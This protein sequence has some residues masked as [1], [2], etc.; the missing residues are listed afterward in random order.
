MKKTYPFY[1]KVTVI[2]FGLTLLVYTLINLR[3]ILTP[4][5]FSLL[6][7]VLLNRLVLK[8]EHFRVP[9][10][11]AISIAILLAFTVIGGVAYFISTQIM[12]FGDDLPLLK[13][14]FLVLFNE[15]Q[16][17]IRDAFGV[18]I[19]QQDIWIAEAESG[20]KPM[21]GQTLGTVAGTI[22]VM[23]LLPV[24]T[25]VLLFYK[26]HFL[27]FLYEVFGDS[28]SE[29]V[30]DVLRETKG[31]IQRYM[32]GL[33]LEGIVVAILNTT[34]LFIFDIKYAI[35]LGVTAAILN[36][37]PYIGGFIAILLPI[38]VA[39]ITKDGIQ[40]QVG[41][42]LAYLFI[43]FL[44]NHVLIPLIVSSRVKINAFISIV[45]VLLGGAM[46]GVPGMFLS[47]P[48][49]G[50]LKIIFDRIEELKPWGKMLGTEEP[51][52]QKIKFV[53]RKRK[54]NVS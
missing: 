28:D 9:K 44:D 46:W 45:I 26:N 2:L 3:D 48:V 36:L 17:V 37:L 15:F 38:I 53:Q 39:T 27:T 8:L 50:V 43:Q 22:G 10:F 25:F 33:L 32:V 18:T 14:R 24:Y 6:L 54:T 13:T 30:A 20:M 47:I 12:S 31:A 49:I 40:T 19:K 52:V 34:A 42:T 35:L 5:C 11:W 21:I 29:R 4:I 7:A 16:H 23:F 41:I 51:T 1:I